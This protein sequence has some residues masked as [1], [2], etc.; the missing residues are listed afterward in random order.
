MINKLINTPPDLSR[1]IQ[2][3]LNSSVAATSVAA[4]TRQ[5]NRLKTWPVLTLFLTASLTC[6]SVVKAQTDSTENAQQASSKP[7]AEQPAPSLPNPLDLNTLLNTYADKSPE[8]DMQMANIDL[9]KASLD[10]NQVGNAWKAN[11]EGRLGRREFAEESQ[12]YNLL[13]L[14]V[15]KV[16]YDFDRS[17]SLLQSDQSKLAQ[18]TEMLSLMENKQRLNVV[19]AY[20]NVLLADFQYRIDNEAM[21]VEYVSYDKV[22]DRHAIGQL[23]D[24]DLLLSEQKYQNSLVKRQQAEQMQ[25]QTRIEL[26]NVI[27]LPDTRPDELKL[28]DLKAFNNRSVK[29]VQLQD[30]Q[31]QVLAN[32]PQLKALKQAQQAQIY[33]L[34]NAQKTSSPTIRAD[35][36][37]GPLSSYPE[38]KEGNWMATLSVDV[39]LYDGGAKSSAMAKVQAQ[40]NKVKAESQQLEQTLRSEVSDIYFKLKLLGAEKKQHQVFGDYADLYL[41]YSRGLYENESSTDLGDA[42]VRLSEA[43]YD[44]VAWRFKQALLWLQLD[45]LQGKTVSITPDKNQLAQTD[46]AK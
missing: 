12:P 2:H 8:I 45:Y 41:D 6:S 23:S 9:A 43:N 27:G 7:V 10:G 26:A 14:H 44:M 22:K 29:D 39:P 11:I 16:L 4:L 24:V 21:A 46:V 1:V 31:K 37:V 13:A 17:D 40:L 30:L 32:N 25:L 34:Q 15:G 19:K 33:A 42:M 18:Q 36:W 5:K 35:A 38:T 20:L 3:R 28:P